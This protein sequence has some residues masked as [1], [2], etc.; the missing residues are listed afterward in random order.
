LRTL[1]G[2][3]ES[4]LLKPLIK[5]IISRDTDSART[6]LERGAPP[7]GLYEDSG[8]N[9][10]PLIAAVVSNK[11]AIVDLVINNG[12]EVNAQN[13]KGWTALH[14]AAELSMKPVVKRLLD[15]G[16][17]IDEPTRDHENK[18][19]LH[20][21]AD[22]RTLKLLLECG[23]RHIPDA[24]GELPLLAAA[25]E[26][27]TKV[28]R[29]LLESG[30]SANDPTRRA[31]RHAR[32]RRRPSGPRRPV[33]AVPALAC[34]SPRSY[35]TWQLGGASVWPE[36]CGARRGNRVNELHRANSGKN[37]DEVMVVV[38]E[39][40]SNVE[41]SRRKDVSGFWRRRRSCHL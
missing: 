18:T 19:A 16:A 35:P 39:E 8:E 6:L 30:V 22:S 12:A 32:R 9:S 23:A 10:T 5:A 27:N 41:T 26:G 33:P 17:N 3:S 4:G 20:L 34:L 40:S 7:N 25:K 11:L 31:R 36:V 21:A 38:V 24:S 1:L 28:V 15:S 14:Y 2:L 37:G 29:A 13:S